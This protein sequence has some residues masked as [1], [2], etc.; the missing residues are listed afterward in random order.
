MALRTVEQQLETI[1]NFLN[2]RQYEQYIIPLLST[3]D[4]KYNA[5][6]NANVNHRLSNIIISTLNS[7]EN[8][9]VD[10]QG[11]QYVKLEDVKDVLNNEL[12]TYLS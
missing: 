2:K 1:K 11:E 4:K 9:S 3:L 10:I 6:F 8:K 5:Q 12:N 7:L